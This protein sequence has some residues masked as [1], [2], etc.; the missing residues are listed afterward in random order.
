[1]KEIDAVG[2]VYDLADTVVERRVPCPVRVECAAAGT[3]RE[4]RGDCREQPEG[5]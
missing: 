1:V 5:N 4:R 3:R 2:G